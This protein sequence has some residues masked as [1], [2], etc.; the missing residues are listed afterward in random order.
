MAV[1]DE[2]QADAVAKVF[3]HNFD[4]PAAWLTADVEAIWFLDQAAASK[5][6]KG[7]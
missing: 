2:A 5:I 3:N 6:P 7:L 1:C 4:L